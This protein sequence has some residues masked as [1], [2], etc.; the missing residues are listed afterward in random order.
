MDR[1]AW[2]A[3]VHRIAKSWTSLSNLARKDVPHVLIP[4]IYEYVSLH[5]KRDF[6]GAT[7][8]RVLRWGD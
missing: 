8:L 4:R 1:G 2:W 5:G 7:K 6:A 3:M